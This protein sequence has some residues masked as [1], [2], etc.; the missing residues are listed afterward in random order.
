MCTFDP[1]APLFGSSLGA[2]HI[3]ARVWTVVY[4]VLARGRASWYVDCAVLIGYIAY[5]V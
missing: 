4:G 3:Y 1:S 5:T 2:R